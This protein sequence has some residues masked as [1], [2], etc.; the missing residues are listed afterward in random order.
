M[1]TLGEPG[2]IH[3][4]QSTYELV[5]RRAAADWVCRGEIEVKGKGKLV[6]WW[7]KYAVAQGQ[8]GQGNGQP[9]WQ[10][11]PQGQ[12]QPQ[13]QQQQ[14]PQQPQQQPH[15]QGEQHVEQ[16]EQAQSAQHAQV[17]Q[18][19]QAQAQELAAGPRK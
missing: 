2:Q 4:A 17:Q 15:P 3:V 18:A 19:E 9:K 10:A 8:E 1:Q 5:R 13:P 6:T 7:Y 14:Q 11:R 12:Q 16:Q